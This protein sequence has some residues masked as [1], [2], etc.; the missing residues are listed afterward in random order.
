MCSH[1]HSTTNGL[2]LDG[3]TEN[4]APFNTGTLYPGPLARATHLA[5]LSLLTEQ[6]SSGREPL[7]WTWRDLCRRLGIVYGGRMVRTMTRLKNGK[8]L[9]SGKGCHSVYEARDVIDPANEDYR[10]WVGST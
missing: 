2:P 9:C 10:L 6:P 4:F 5:F 3:G 1:C 7:T 8:L